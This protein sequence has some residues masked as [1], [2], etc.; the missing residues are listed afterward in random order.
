MKS[1]RCLIPATGYW[2]WVGPTGNR[3]PYIFRPV[4]D[5]ILA[6]AGVYSW[7]KDPTKAED[8][9]TRWVLTAAHCSPRMRHRRWR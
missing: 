4:Y 1:N 9:P 3:Q 8:D 7:W 2:E 5:E 6:F